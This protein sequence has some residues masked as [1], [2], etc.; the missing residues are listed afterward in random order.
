MNISILMKLPT[1]LKQMF[2]FQ[3]F[4]IFV[5]H[6]NFKSSKQDVKINIGNTG[7][8]YLKDEL[9]IK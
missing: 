2:K 5:K 7:L 3:F 1:K 6:Y 4:D 9:Q 8:D